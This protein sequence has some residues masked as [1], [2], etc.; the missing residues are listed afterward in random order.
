MPA[1][2]PVASIISRSKVVRCSSRWAS[3]SR[4]ILVS[5]ARRALSSALMPFMAWFSV[6]RGVT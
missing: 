5:S 4:P 1:Q 2:L 3:S 6:G